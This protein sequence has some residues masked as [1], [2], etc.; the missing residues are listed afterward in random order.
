[1]ADDLEEDGENASPAHLRLVDSYPNGYVDESPDT[2]DKPHAYTPTELKATI[3]ELIMGYKER[4]VREEV[5]AIF[6]EAE[7]STGHVYGRTEPAPAGD[8]LD[9][10]HPWSGPKTK[11]AFPSYIDLN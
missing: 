3:H 8:E 4:G 9:N 11:V 10:L 6:D 1:M 2:D 5:R 7:K